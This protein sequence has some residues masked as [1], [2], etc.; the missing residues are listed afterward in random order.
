MSRTDKDVPWQIAAEWY[1]PLHMYCE[2]DTLHHYRPSVLNGKRRDCDLPK[3]PGGYLHHSSWRGDWRRDVYRC[4]WSPEFPWKHRR[5]TVT[6]GPHRDER[7][8]YWGH[9]RRRKRD[10]CRAAKK[11][12]RST[13]YIESSFITVDQHR[14]SPGKGWWD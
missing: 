5:Y 9:E 6:R 2:H 8:L 3:H 4:S 11:E 7:R 1:E 14:H 10:E 12:H 13:G